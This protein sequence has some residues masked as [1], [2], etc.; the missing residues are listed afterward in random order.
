MDGTI[1]MTQNPLLV[2]TARVGG[3]SFHEDDMPES[4]VVVYQPELKGRIRHDLR[5]LRVGGNSM[6]PRIPKGPI[7][8]FNLN[9]REFMDQKIYVVREPFSDPP[10][11]TVK[12]IRKVSQKHFKGFALVSENRKYLP[13]MTDLDWHE[14][15]VGRAVWMWRSLEET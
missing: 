9:G 8:A 10:I 11:A 2:A 7:V 14:L 3:C 6:R 15:V 5:A 12:R 1:P 13:E 4:T